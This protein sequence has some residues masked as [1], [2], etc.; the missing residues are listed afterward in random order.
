[1]VRG[2]G[3]MVSGSKALVYCLRLMAYSLW[4]R[5]DGLWFT[6]GRTRLPHALTIA[7]FPK[8]YIVNPEPRTLNL[9]Y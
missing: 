5:V 7:R 1:M 4:S 3:V 6:R 9:S 8:L 2:L